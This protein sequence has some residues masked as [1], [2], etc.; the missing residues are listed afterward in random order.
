VSPQRLDIQMNEQIVEIL[1][2]GTLQKGL[3][4]AVAALR[5][6]DGEDLFETLFPLSVKD[7]DHGNAGCFR[8]LCSGSTEPKVPADCPRSY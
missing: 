2:T 8:R 6:F 3:A 5:E 1:R 4:C 7:S